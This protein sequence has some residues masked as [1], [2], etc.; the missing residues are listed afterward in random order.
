M[1]TWRR[2]LS[3]LLALVLLLTPVTMIPMETDAAS[4]TAAKSSNSDYTL[5]VFDME[6]FLEG[7]TARHVPYDYLKFAT[8]L[9]GI[10]NRERPQLFFDSLE[11]GVNLNAG[12]DIDE[13]WLDYITDSSNGSNMLQ[14]GEDL[15]KYKIERIEG[16]MENFWAVVALFRNYVDGLVLWDDAVPATSNVAS[17]I[18]GVENLLPVRYVTARDDLYTQLMN[19]QGGK[20]TVKR[21]LVGLFDGETM[22]TFGSSVPGAQRTVDPDLESTRSIKTDPYIWAM[23]HYLKKGKTNANLMT[24]S[25]DGRS[26]VYNEIDPNH[27]VDAEFVASNIPYEMQVG[28]IVPIQITIKNTGGIAWEM[29]NAETWPNPVRLSKTDEVSYSWSSIKNGNGGTWQDWL[30]YHSTHF[31]LLASTK[32]LDPSETGGLEGIPASPCGGRASRVEIKRRIAQGEEYTFTCYL[33]AP[34]KPGS[35][36][37][38][39]R[40]LQDK[41][42][43]NFPAAPFGQIYYVGIEVTEDPVENRDVVMCEAED[44]VDYLCAYDSVLHTDNNKGAYDVTNDL[45]ALQ[46]HMVYP[47]EGTVKV[48]ATNTGE[49]EWSTE[50]GYALRY[51]TNDMQWKTIDL[52]E[53]VIGAG[54]SKVFEIPVSAADVAEDG[55]SAENI[56]KAGAEISVMAQ[57]TKKGQAFGE[58][59]TKAV[60]IKPSF[61]GKL[62]AHTVPDSV[63][64]DAKQKVSLTYRNTGSYAWS[65][66]KLDADTTGL[67]VAITTG[68]RYVSATGTGDDYEPTHG[69]NREMRSDVVV[70]PGETY[71]FHVDMHTYPNPL[72][73]YTVATENKTSNIATGLNFILNT[74]GDLAGNQHFSEGYKYVFSQHI[75]D[76]TPLN[77]V[78]VNGNNDSDLRIT[79]ENIPDVMTVDE[80]IGLDLTLKNAGE[81]T[82]GAFELAVLDEYFVIDGE[83]SVNNAAIAAGAATELNPSLCAPSEPGVYVLRLAMIGDDETFRT[84]YEKL[85]RVIEA[86]TERESEDG[87][88]IYLDANY[89]PSLPLEVHHVDA[90]DVN[91]SGSNMAA[92]LLSVRMPQVMR[93]GEAAPVSVTVMN[94]GK[95]PWNRFVDGSANLETNARLDVMSDGEDEKFRITKDQ[96]GEEGWVGDQ[97]VV[98]M[99]QDFD[100]WPGSSTTFTG[101]LHAPNTAGVYMMRTQMS[102]AFGYWAF[103]EELRFPIIVGMNAELIYMTQLKALNNLDHVVTTLVKNT[104]EETWEPLADPAADTGYALKYTFGEET[105]YASMPDSIPAGRAAFADFKFDK[106]YKAGTYEM[107]AE[108]I[109]R[110]EEGEEYR[111][112]DAI[113]TELVID[114]GVQKE[115]TFATESELNVKDTQYGVQVVSARM[116]AAMKPGQRLPVTVTIKN[117]GKSDLI[118]KYG[119]T[120]G[121]NDGVRVYFGGQ[122][123]NQN[124]KED[125]WQSDPTAFDEYNTTDYKLALAKKFFVYNAQGD[126]RR[127]SRYGVTINDRGNNECNCLDM[128]DGTVLV[129]GDTYTYQGW[130]V[131]PYTEG[132][133]E[134]KIYAYADV[135]KEIRSKTYV[136]SI[137][138]NASG[139]V[140]KTENLEQKLVSSTATYGKK[141]GLFNTALLNA[142]Y[143]ISNKAF[144]FD[145]SPDDTIAP[146]DDR[147]QPIGTDAATLRKLFHAQMEQAQSRRASG[148]LDVQGTGIFTIGGFYPWAYKY[149]NDVDEQSLMDPFHGEFHMIDIASEYGGQTDADAFGTIG[150]S[151]ASVYQHIAVNLSGSKAVQ[152]QSTFNP[153]TYCTEKYDPKKNYIMFYMGDYDGGSWVG[154]LINAIY[155]EKD[156]NGNITRGKLP[157]GWQINT[158]LAD[159]I[160]HVYNMLYKNAT[161]KDFFVV[162]NN[163]TGY[164][165]VHW[166]LNP[167]DDSITAEQTAQIR[168]DWIAYNQSENRE[169]SLGIQGF[170]QPTTSSRLT[171]QV[172]DVY[173]QTTP[174]GVAD[175]QGAYIGK[176]KLHHGIYDAQA[177]DGG[178][179]FLYNVQLARLDDPATYDANLAKIVGGI[180]NAMLNND[181]MVSASSVKWTPSNVLAVVD[182]YNRVYPNEKLTAVDPYTYFRLYRQKMAAEGGAGMIQY[183]EIKLAARNV[184]FGES[185]RLTLAFTF[186]G[187]DVSKVNMKQDAGIIVWREA[188]EASQYNMAR[189]NVLYGETIRGMEL[190]PGTKNVYVAQTNPIV[191]KDFDRYL[192]IRAWVTTGGKQYFSNIEVYSPKRYATTVGQTSTKELRDLAVSMLNYSA[193][194]QTYANEVRDADSVLTAA[195]KKLVFDP[196]SIRLP[197][198]IDPAKNVT[199]TAGYFQR[200][201]QNIRLSDNFNLLF[202]WQI[203]PA[204]YANATD[205]G[206]LVWNE[207]QYHALKGAPSVSNAG[208]KLAMTSTT[209]NGAT[210][211]GAEYTGVAARNIDQTVY[212]CAYMTINGV[213]YYSD[214]INYSVHRYAQNMIA[215]GGTM[216]TLAK[217]VVV[218]GEAAKAYYESK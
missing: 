99:D 183:P 113:S 28:Q 93:K 159:R 26:E 38:A 173:R 70:N 103:G 210:C 55:K 204:V 90:D 131:A 48:V 186:E 206:I 42:N 37:F 182:Y 123:F 114:E 158:N 57:M 212:A 164:F 148:L 207:S 105:V 24:Y 195:Q 7:K 89:R 62:I 19:G 45:D 63:M 75:E 116:P 147:T 143:Y 208:T 152:T 29:T 35:Y 11:S 172:M 162:G 53:D 2:L 154:N 170:I 79:A 67:R 217:R 74:Q 119:H 13:V 30:D 138:V 191:A 72:S 161:E 115:T 73:V 214:L 12:I 179:P 98:E 80:V 125:V 8:A 168:K 209:I 3:A 78:V 84:G 124:Y 157:V 34:T 107:T 1:K 87:S 49:T 77:E 197:A 21:T 136:V 181:G 177:A 185:M 198:A 126:T 76:E 135:N 9:Q 10:V 112:G 91:M 36:E 205:S 169:F 102:N 23:E 211:Y 180:H 190:M 117:T 167:R 68:T 27:P 165:N 129:S 86:D 95:K 122:G 156:E 213:T 64:A 120:N 31:Q 133:Y 85:I 200:A 178:T 81:S 92:R 104:G 218:Y 145:L 100:V 150:L 160:P 5:F 171:S 109:Y 83:S 202:F 15:S 151:N 111:L 96:A 101:W 60:E 61:A 20:W 82:V 97:N 134:F 128:K 22:P 184:S 118:S 6:S 106:I 176:V 4:T 59:F 146:M 66:S 141:I 188:S 50:S 40:M 142:D 69:Y 130:I 51:M 127:T 140:S 54:E 137:P 39:L 163:G 56:L 153:K 47:H 32:M 44:S 41:A 121:A 18:A 196:Q 155:N 187:L 215:R 33:K 193:E 174:Y 203:D 144:F 132:T 199:D 108:V 139:E 46:A 43:A 149:S 189:N 17:T 88:T 201:Y 192:Y 175:A 166:A 94:V 216:G 58:T 65:G 71:T 16:T 25:I 52:G 110:T 194:A 14:N